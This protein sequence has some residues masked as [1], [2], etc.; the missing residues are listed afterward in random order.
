MP[1]WELHLSSFC[2]ILPKCWDLQAYTTA[3]FFNL[4]LIKLKLIYRSEY[5]NVPLCFCKSLKKNLQVA[6]VVNGI[7]LNILNSCKKPRNVIPA[8]LRKPACIK[9][10]LQ[11]WVS[12]PHEC[13][14]TGNLSFISHLLYLVQRQAITGISTPRSSILHPHNW[15]YV[16]SNSLVQRRHGTRWLLP[17]GMLIYTSTLGFLLL[18]S[19]HNIEDVPNAQV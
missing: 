12:F 19:H 18:T 8:H 2:L 3:N 9:K 1:I 13:I 6:I 15:V 10:K 5:F 16:A 11:N 14:P 7:N 17:P 4:L